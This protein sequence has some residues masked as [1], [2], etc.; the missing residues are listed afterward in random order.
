MTLLTIPAAELRRLAG[1][2][3]SDTSQD[4]ALL[5]VQASEQPAHEYALDPDTLTSALSDAGLLAVLTLGV[6]AI[7]G[8][9]LFAA[10]GPRPRRDRRHRAGR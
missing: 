3:A 10:I 5:A 7:V 4:A 2:D 8:R 9:E 6:A 1:I